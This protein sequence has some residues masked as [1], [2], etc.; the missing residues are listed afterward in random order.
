MRHPTGIY[1]WRGSIVNCLIFKPFFMRKIICTATALLFVTLAFCQ[2]V[3]AT[4]NCESTIKEYG[5]LWQQKAAEYRALCYQAF[6]LAE[7]RLLEIP[8]KKFRK[9]HIAIIT[10]LDE[11]ILDNS[12]SEARLIKEGKQYNSMSWKE[13]L[14][15]SAAT[16]V[17]GAA[18]FLQKAKQRGATIFY[19]S[20][21]KV[22][23][24]E[25]TLLNLQKLG[26]PDA[27]TSHMFFQKESSSKE[28]RRQQVMQR[29]NVVM[30]LGDNLNDFTNIFENKNITDRFAET[31]KVIAEW[32]KKFIVLPNAVYG[33][34]ENALYDYKFNYSAEQKQAIRMQ[35]L[36]G[37]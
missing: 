22:A 14:D 7:L 2:D 3:P 13:W 30:L 15:R 23:D 27:D 35:L 36:V 9:G 34:W 19:I 12:Y 29:Y 5:V 6:N 16:G 26:L 24:I 25:S 8:R 31:D 20:N 18:A 28:S 37:Y 32:G 17:P 10:D 1:P 21:R 11:T 33:D 4:S